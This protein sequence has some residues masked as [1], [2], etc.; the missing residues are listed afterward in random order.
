MHPRTMYTGLAALIAA[1]ATGPSY[2]HTGISETIGFW[3]GLT[4]PFTGMD[5]LLAMLAVGIWAAQLGGRAT[6]LV[7]ITFVSVMSI[8]GVA[9]MGGAAPLLTEPGIVI[10]VLLLGILIMTMIRLPLAVSAALVG[11][12]AAFHGAAHGLEVPVAVS[13]AAYAVGFIAATA[14]LHACG[15]AIGSR[16]AGVGRLNLIRYLGGAVTLGGAYLAL[17]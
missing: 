1:V 16:L 7:P 5:H 17:A 12:F 6:W 2:A 8:S 10:S 11:V 4:H 3:H 15:L 9:A 14:A 13:G